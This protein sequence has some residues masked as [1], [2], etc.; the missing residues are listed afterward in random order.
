MSLANPGIE[1]DMAQPD[2]SLQSRGAR[3]DYEEL[4]SKYNLSLIN[5]LRGFGEGEDFERLWVPST[6]VVKSVW[7]LIDSFWQ[8]ARDE[9]VLSIP[10][11]HTE[12][13]EKETFITHD[14]LFSSVTF[15]DQPGGVV[16]CITGIDTQSEQCPSMFVRK[17]TTSPVTQ[18]ANSRACHPK[19]N[20]VNK[21]NRN[22]QLEVHPL[23]L[24]AVNKIVGMENRRQGLAP[25]VEDLVNVQVKLDD[26]V[27]AL[28]IDPETTIVRQATHQGGA[29]EITTSLL[30]KLCLEIE[31][32]PIQE[33]SDHAVLRLE[34]GLRENKAAPIVSGICRPEIAGTAFDFLQKLIRKAL[35]SY[36]GLTQYTS[37]ENRYDP[38]PGN[39]WLQ[40]SVD[41]RVRLLTEVLR[42]VELSQQLLNVKA[43]VERI[44]FDVRIVIAF[45]GS[46]DVDKQAMLMAYERAIQEKIDARLETHFLER[47]DKNKLRRGNLS[48]SKT[49]VIVNWKKKDE[50]SHD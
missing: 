46:E 4:L 45:E 31:G 13:F 38:G 9:L 48:E 36:R 33:V 30:D 6:D 39:M 10:A 40:S 43:T 1:D 20:N 24:E 26:T 37:S 34:F 42:G 14:N 17:I 3:L 16:L 8:C 50:K 29:S 28:G 35:R 41:Q 18:V 12:H 32:V 25:S 11:P 49:S 2:R 22:G 21:P 44:E 7:N 15:F 5:S 23:H 19:E 47:Q 27:L